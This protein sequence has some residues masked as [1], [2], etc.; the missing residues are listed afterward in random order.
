MAGLVWALQSLKDR[1]ILNCG[2]VHMHMALPELDG[3][4]C[5]DFWSLVEGLKQAFNILR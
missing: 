4:F 2:G 5:K 3:A 1:A